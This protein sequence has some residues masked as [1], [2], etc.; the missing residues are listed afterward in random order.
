M[1]IYQT[2]V[3]GH[4]ENKNVF[5]I[6]DKITVALTMDKAM[7][8]QKGRA[9]Y[10]ADSK[11][12][13]NGLVFSLDTKKGFSN[14]NATPTEST[15]LVFEH[16]V[17]ANDAFTQGKEFS[18]KSSSDLIISGIS[19]SNGYPPAF[20]NTTYPISLSNTVATKFDKRN[21]TVAGDT[22][23]GYTIEKKSGASWDTDVF[24]QES[25]I[26]DGYAIFTLNATSARTGIML[27]LSTDNP[28]GSYKTGAM[29]FN[30][31]FVAYFIAIIKISVFCVVVANIFYFIV[32]NVNSVFNGF[33][34]A[35]WIVGG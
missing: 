27:G 29:A 35:V 13:I 24:S 14:P 33:V 30:L 25:F 7:Q 32:V 34:T 5:E 2:S 10:A 31:D 15:K 1:N 22:F 17:Q 4:P 20:I 21:L 19:D 3:D 12:I 8:Y 16:T 11:I 23:Q 9:G 28:D 6:G 26:G 18:I